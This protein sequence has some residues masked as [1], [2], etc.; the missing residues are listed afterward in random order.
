MHNKAEHRFKVF[1]CTSSKTECIIDVRSWYVLQQNLIRTVSTGSHGGFA[2]QVSN[3]RIDGWKKCKKY[4]KSNKQLFCQLSMTLIFCIHKWFHFS[5]SYTLC[6]VRFS[7]GCLVGIEYPLQSTFEN[8]EIK[9]W[10]LKI[11]KKMPDTILNNC[12]TL[13]LNCHRCVE[14]EF[15]YLHNIYAFLVLMVV[16]AWVCIM[17]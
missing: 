16:I 12:S 3:N 6:F 7:I 2:S 11:E 8:W 14:E 13:I 17:V 5:T 15:G 9:R 1:L 10:P 4:I